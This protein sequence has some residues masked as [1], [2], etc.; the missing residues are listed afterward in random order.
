[1][2]LSKSLKTNFL[3]A[4]GRGTETPSYYGLQGYSLPSIRG[5]GSRAMRGA[6]EGLLVGEGL[7][8]APQVTISVGRQAL[9]FQFFYILGLSSVYC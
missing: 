7:L 8:F 2:F 1:M 5:G 4:G 9:F 3:G 6:G